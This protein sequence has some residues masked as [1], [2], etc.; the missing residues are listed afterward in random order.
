MQFK[1]LDPEFRLEGERVYLRPITGLDTNMVLAW[2]NAPFVTEH[3]FYRKPISVSEHE[4]WLSDKV[5][6]G[7]VY[8][9]I[10][11]LKEGD[12]PVG[13]VYLQHYDE[14]DNSME[15]GL[16]MDEKFAGGRGI[17]TECYELMTCS[18]AKEVLKLS[19]LRARI[20][21]DNRGSIRVHEK[22]GFVTKE[23]VEEKV[24]PTGEFEIA[25]QMEKI[26]E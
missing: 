10:A 16:F 5:A 2:R 22:C 1:P 7:L 11:C 12:V 20:I 25:L 6:Q 19:K 24:I 21:A 3:F 17:A 23:T 9:F 8:Q 13:S 18:F 26:I 15:S 14:S 4:K